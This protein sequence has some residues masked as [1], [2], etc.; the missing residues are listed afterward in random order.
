MLRR[1]LPALILGI[2]GCAVLVALGVWQLHRAEWKG[3]M[4]A[5]LRAG[6]EADPVF[7]PARIDPS[8]KYLPVYVRGRTTGDEIL[9]VSG[10]DRAAGYQVVSGLVTEDGRRIMVDRGFIPQEARHDPRPPADLVVDGNLHWPDERTSATPEPNLAENIWFAR[11]VDRMAEALHTEPVLVVA[12]ATAGEVQGITPIPLTVEG[13][14]D[15][16]RNYAI[17]WFLM[18]AAWAGMTAA[19]IWRIHSRSY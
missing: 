8:M 3:A 4:L 7:L 10:T 1:T 16:H 14:P 15:N 11:E 12:R 18:A 19:L 2:A 9:F 5:E 6:I 13:I 17:Q